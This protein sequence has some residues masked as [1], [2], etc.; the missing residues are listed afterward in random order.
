MTSSLRGVRATTLVALP[1]EFYLYR[2][3]VAPVCKSKRP[4]KPKE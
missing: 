3:A 4:T 1:K 2:L